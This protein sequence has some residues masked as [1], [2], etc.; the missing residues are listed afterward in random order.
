MVE[1]S[2][3]VASGLP[4]AGLPFAGWETAFERSPLGMSVVVDQTITRVNA[5][6]CE[7]LGHPAAALIGTNAL[8]LVERLM[9]ADVVQRQIEESAA[10][11]GNDPRRFHLEGELRRADGSVRW[12]AL[13]AVVVDDAESLV[14]V[15]T[16]TDMTDLHRARTRAATAER[17]ASNQAAVLEWIARG[18]PL[19]VIAEACVQLVEAN[20]VGGRSSIYLLRGSRLE[21]LAGRAPDAVNA[22]VGQP[23][24]GR[25]RS[26]CDAAILDGT[27]AVAA[28]LAHPDIPAGLRELAES[29][30]VRAAW[31]QPITSISTGRPVGSLST[32]YRSG[33]EPSAHERRVGDVAC[34]LVAIALERADAEARLARQ[35][36]HDPLTGLPNRSLLVDRLERALARPPVEGRSVA[37]LFCDIDRFKVVNDSLGHAVGD[38]VLVAFGQRFRAAVDARHSVARFGGDEFVVLLEDALADE[39]TELANALSDAVAAPFPLP[40]GGELYLTASIGITTTSDERTGDAWLRDADSAMYRAK[41]EGRNRHVVFDSAM[42]DAAMARLEVERDLRHAVDRDELVV[43]YQ[44]VVDLESG[45]IAGAEALVRWQHPTRGL[46]PPA[47]FIPVAEDTGIAVQI[48]RHVLRIAVAAMARL[49]GGRPNDGFRLGVNVSG[50]QI[51]APGLV[52][53]VE[54]TCAEH[55]WPLTALVLEITESAILEGVTAPLDQLHRLHELGVELAIDDFGT[56]ASSLTRL[57]L[58][59]VSQMK[60]DQSFVAAIDQPADRPVAIVDAVTALAR[61]LGL[62]VTAE[63]VESRRQL[64]H[65]RAIGCGSAQGYYFSKPLPIEEFT[66]LV[67]AEPIW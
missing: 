20:G 24:R 56:G 43:H 53:H 52:G 39:P 25:E 44:A 37:I 11:P 14:V 55:D 5:A 21:L 47:E 13:E 36:T 66:Q 23:I 26:L 9:G 19:P 54:A 58:V 63:G 46:L 8:D 32:L 35:A 60:V 49:H 42:R 10:T 1:Q 59:P 31:S 6:L 34:S 28:D 7:L 3:P 15:A 40:T 50:R 57:A 67:E 18:E 16:V 48:D 27:V 64:E 17:L 30:G 22:W 65:L 45:R 4:V 51:G 61:A 41:A 29:A 62:Q 12:A 2:A 33:H 38:E